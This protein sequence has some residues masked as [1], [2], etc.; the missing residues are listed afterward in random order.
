MLAILIPGPKSITGDH[1][2]VY[3][4][5]L[6]DKLVLLW[7]EGI[8]CYDANQYKQESYFLFKA[9]VIWTIGDFSTYGMMARCVTKGFVGCPVCGLGFRSRRSKVLHKNVFC[10]CARRWLDDDHHM[11]M[12]IE[13]FG[14]ME[15]RRAPLP[16]TSAQALQYANARERWILEEG[17]T[18][19][20]NDP[21]RQN[22][23]KRKSAFYRLPYWSVGD[24]FIHHNDLGMDMMKF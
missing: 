13:N 7:D 12:D 3:L 19:I 10:N 4:D 24:F 5:P 14:I 20:A 17:G 21:V 22:G 2:D 23:I 11:R 6:I 18:P 16:V 8:W 1:I 9:M 15:H